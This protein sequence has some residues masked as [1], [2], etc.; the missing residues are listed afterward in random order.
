MCFGFPFATTISRSLRANTIGDSA[1]SPACTS[2]CMFGWS[3]E[4]KTSPSAPSRICAASD[5]DPAKLNLTIVP[6]WLFSKSAPIVVNAAFNEDAANTVIVPLGPDGGALPDPDG[7]HAL[8]RPT[9]P[10]RSSAVTTRARIGTSAPRQLDDHVRSFDHGDRANAGGEA[11]LVGCLPGNERN[12]PVRAGLNL[13]LR[14]DA[15]L[16]DASHDARKVIAR[17]SPDGGFRFQLRRVRHHVARELPRI[18]HALAACRPDGRQPTAVGQA[19][20]AVDADTQQLGDLANL[21]GSD[22]RN[23][24][25]CAVSTYETSKIQRC[26]SR[27]QWLT[28]CRPWMSMSPRLRRSSKRR[29]AGFGGPSRQRRRKRPNR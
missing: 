23:S 6:G 3:A 20:N 15:I 26:P 12:E 2:F 4:A 8:A 16:D 24:S 5:D 9:V 1:V 18:D 25:I 21:I 14:H 22:T 28:S 13:D 17:G 29:C 10:A 27:V 19:S 7:P 11:E